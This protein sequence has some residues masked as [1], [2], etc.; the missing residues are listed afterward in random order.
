MIYGL[1]GTLKRKEGKSV[2]V[3]VGGFDFKVAVPL[4]T[5]ERLPAVGEEVEFFTYFH[6]RE[7][8][9]DLYGFL[10]EPERHLFEAL[11]SVTGIGPKSA[12]SILGVAPAEELMTTIAKG[13]VDMLQRSSGIGRKTAERIVLELKDKMEGRG[14]AETGGLVEADSDI[15]E[16]L[17]SLGYPVR[18]AREA[19]RKIDPELTTAS[20]RL[21]DALKKIRN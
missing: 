14:S 6:L 17:V 13:E 9:A 5:G 16:A 10:G 7:G 3:G 21:R 18:L 12:L 8:G 15:A 1:R 11:I 19:V 20:D 4:T 2:V